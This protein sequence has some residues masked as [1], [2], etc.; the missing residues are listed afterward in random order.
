MQIP[1]ISLVQVKNHDSINIL[2]CANKNPSLNNPGPRLC[3]LN[4]GSVITSL[5]MITV[6]TERDLVFIVPPA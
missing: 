1:Y 6:T 5:L 2:L 3:G 4:A